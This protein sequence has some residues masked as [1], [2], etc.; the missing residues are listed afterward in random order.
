MASLPFAYR[1]LVAAARASAPVLALS[2]S[3]LGRGM[4][5]RRRAHG[6]LIE[7]AE[8][9][10]RAERPLVWFHAPSFGEGLQA[11]AVAR[12]LRV[13]VPEVEVVH[14]YFSPSAEAMA[15]RFGADM[16]G[17]L[18]WDQE[19]VLDPVLDALAPDLLVFTKTE[20]W[21]VLAERARDRG[22]PVALVAASV[23]P[24]AGRL[25]W[26][27]RSLLQSTW[28][29]MAAGLACSEEDAAGLVA[30][31]VHGDC[32]TVTGDPGIDS[33]MERAGAADP[34]A[35]YLAPFH[36]QPRPTVVAGSTWPSDEKVLL[37]ALAALRTTCPDLRVILAPHEP[38]EDRVGK[39]LG[40]FMEGGW[41]PSTLGH[42]ER[43]GHADD[44]DAIVVERVGVLAHLYTVGD[45]A[46]VGGGFH[47]A[48]VHSVL[49]PAAAGLPV[50][51]GPRHENARAAS[52]LMASG[53]ARVVADADEAWPAM[54]E[55]LREPDAKAYASERALGYIE[56]HRGAA[57]RTARV[58]A[59]LMYPSDRP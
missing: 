1:L 8:R 6:T 43:D 32:V 56:S 53:A 9:R 42:V 15:A 27:A 25:R 24:G 5:G 22:I 33:A 59:S 36:A 18:P 16:S 3:K 37:P 20:A 55:W 11:E 50:L 57:A 35:P 38:S 41:R 47:H 4:A 23:P 30:L 39:L 28:E 49:E 7:W 51:F 12:A 2:P 40:S 10:P 29:G 58:L 17:Y 34:S 48:G 19:S 13:L 26:P 45:I 54:L 31:G 46:W 21:P 52:H 44:C 14:T